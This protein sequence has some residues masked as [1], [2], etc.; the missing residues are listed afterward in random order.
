MVQSKE[1]KDLH[2]RV[3]DLEE[4]MNDRY[5][6]HQVD[7]KIK[8]QIALHER[9]AGS[10]LPGWIACVLVLVFVMLPFLL[11]WIPKTGKAIFCDG[12]FA[13]FMKT[14]HTK[15]WDQINA[16]RGESSR[17]S[18]MA[19]WVQNT[20]VFSSLGKIQSDLNEVKQ[21]GRITHCDSV[22][23]GKYSIVY[24]RHDS[25][26]VK[27]ETYDSRGTLLA[28]AYIEEPMTPE[29]YLKFI[30]KQKDKCKESIFNQCHER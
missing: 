3:L 17:A 5:Q 13:G 2:K 14:E 15:M 9:E 29:E 21:Y 12:N 20:S 25:G 4:R 23:D 16:A 10:Y 30:K 22:V 11:E 8:E 7:N 24:T 27:Q 26:H 19:D 1:V 6:K 18:I 28:S